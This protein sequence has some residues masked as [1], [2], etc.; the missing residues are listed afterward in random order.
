MEHENENKKL[1]KIWEDILDKNFPLVDKLSE[2]D[3]EFEA[4]ALLSK[5]SFRS[6]TKI[7]NKEIFD[8]ILER[9]DN[10]NSKLAE[11]LNKTRDKKSCG[12]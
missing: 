11:K 7:N 5:L 4:L 12:Y 1:E 3:K 9:F 10:I 2:K 6:I 8:Q